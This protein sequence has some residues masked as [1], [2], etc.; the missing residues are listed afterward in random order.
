MFL[1]STHCEGLTQITGG[2][3]FMELGELIKPETNGD[4]LRMSP[5]NISH[6]HLLAQNGRGACKERE[7]IL[8]NFLSSGSL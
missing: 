7:R 1:Y 3:W 5:A 2:N 4:S 8:Y 6:A